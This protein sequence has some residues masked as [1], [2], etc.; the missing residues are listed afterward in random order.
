[1]TRKNK[2]RVRAV[3]ALCLGY[4]LSQ[5]MAPWAQAQSA[6]ANKELVRRFNAACNERRYGR[7]DELVQ[8]A[9]RRHCQATALVTVKSLDEFKEFLSADATT[10][11][12]AR[13][14]MLKLI[15]EGDQVAFWGTFSGT[16][17]GAM[18][19]FPPS[20]KK[21]ELDVS[22]VF[23]IEGGKIAELWITWDNMAVFT[24]LELKPA[25]GDLQTEKPGN[26]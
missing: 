18:G 14:T 2:N 9:F 15:E 25:G 8:P 13:V 17:Q 23:R 20:M 6:S 7:L 21:V 4:A 19:P 22:G 12:D 16:Q 5:P 24:Q 1:M 26:E 11:P 3:A 10:F